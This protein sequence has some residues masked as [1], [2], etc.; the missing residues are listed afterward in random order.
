[1]KLSTILGAVILLGVLV[2]CGP[3]DVNQTANSAAATAAAA[4]PPGAEATAAAVAS[5][6]TVAAMV[7]TVASAV[8]DPSVQG[9]V[10]SAFQSLNNQVTV[11][12]GQA[13]TLNALSAIPN[14]TNY[15][16]TIV[17]APAGAA[18]AKGQVIKEA[19]SGNISLSP[20]EYSKYFTAS[21]DYKIQLDVTTNG[22]STATHQFTV[23]V[24]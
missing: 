24:P 13:L 10:D 16:M 22:N 3:G 20:D 23:T 15:K 18:S 8:S 21:G 4:V 17:D 19:S 7:N 11:Q 9:A 5:D 1:M 6:P 14:V 2:S 12:Q